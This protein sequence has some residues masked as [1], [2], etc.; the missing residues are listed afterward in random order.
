MKKQ[1]ISPSLHLVL[2]ALLQR[3]QPDGDLIAVNQEIRDDCGLSERTVRSHLAELQRLGILRL[4]YPANHI[5]ERRP[6]KVVMMRRAPTYAV[7]KS[8]L[9]SFQSQAPPTLKAL[10]QPAPLAG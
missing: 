8:K 4:K 2:A 6:G 10:Y 5:I 1:Q 9:R 3:A 7:D